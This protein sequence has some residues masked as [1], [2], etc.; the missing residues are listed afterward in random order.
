MI[1]VTL[2][3]NIYISAFAFKGEPKRLLQMAGDGQIE[4]A[5]SQP[6][7]DEVARILSGKKFAWPPE[8]VEQALDAIRSIAQMVTSTQPLN[9]VPADPSD[10]KIVECAIASSSDVL[11]SGDKHLLRLKSYAGMPIIRVAEFLGPDR[12]R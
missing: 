2:D 5:V 8:Q 7:L 11:L 12:T 3:S 6:I 9:A 10:N 1:R 4:I